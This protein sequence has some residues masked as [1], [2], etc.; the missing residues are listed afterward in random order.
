MFNIFCKPLTRVD[1]NVTSSATIMGLQGSLPKH[2]SF[3]AFV[4][5][6]GR[7]SFKIMNNQGERTL[8]CRTPCKIE[9]LSE[10]MPSKRTRLVSTPYQ[11]RKGFIDRQ[12]FQIKNISCSSQISNTF[13]LR[14]TCRLLCIHVY[15]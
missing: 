6:C 14:N 8:P 4:D 15:A 7:S 9:K 13:L 11:L 2:K 3:I 1:S 12:K 10:T 5:H